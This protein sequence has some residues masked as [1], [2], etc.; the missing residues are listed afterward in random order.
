[1]WMRRP[2]G[3]RKS[4]GRFRHKVTDSERNAERT[5][6]ADAGDDRHQRVCTRKD[7][8][9]RTFYSIPLQLSVNQQGNE[10]EI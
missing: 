2:N 7:D 9:N 5:C 10:S 3:G 8:L 6:E 4:K 1:M